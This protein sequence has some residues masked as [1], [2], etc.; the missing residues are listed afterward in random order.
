MKEEAEKENSLQ[1]RIA[2]GALLDQKQ[3]QKEIA[4]KKFYA[5][6]GE[7][8]GKWDNWDI[9]LKCENEEIQKKK[10]FENLYSEGKI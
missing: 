8:Q 7:C 9:V 10:E 4:W 5:P 3:K 2:I 1:S 6:S